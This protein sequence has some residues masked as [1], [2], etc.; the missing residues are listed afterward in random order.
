MAAV[1]ALEARRAGATCDI[2]LSARLEKEQR[3]A[4]ESLLMI[5]GSLKFLAMQELAIRGDS[6]DEGNLQ[7]LLLL[8]AEDIPCLKVNF[9]RKS[10][11]PKINLFKLSLILSLEL[12]KQ[13][14]QLD[15]AFHSK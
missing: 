12:A 6:Q 2:Q 10:V 8:R 14:V 3:E 5:I 4:R 7:K 11:I 13:E 9:N 15:F 1:T